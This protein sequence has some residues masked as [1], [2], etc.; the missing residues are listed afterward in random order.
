[1][2]RRRSGFAVGHS[3]KGAAK[4]RARPSLM[5]RFWL[6]ERVDELGGR[7]RVR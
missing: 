5:G 4:V 6:V 1:V 2:R 3:S 7:L